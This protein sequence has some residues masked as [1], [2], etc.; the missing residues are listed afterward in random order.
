VA[1]PRFVRY[2]LTA[3]AIVAGALVTRAQIPTGDADLHLQLA[4][5]LFEETRYPEALEAYDRAITA[6][7]ADA[8]L[9]TRA[10]KGKVRTALRL[11]QFSTALEEA[12]RLRAAAAEDAEALALHG[13]ALWS[14]GLFDE[15][16]DAYDAALVRAPGA[17][18]A[19]LGRARSLATKSR[20]DEALAE[21]LAAVAAAPRGGEKHPAK[22]EK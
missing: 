19:R 10:R 8:E 11:A 22:G 21:A 17:S 4:G 2:T 1:P 5:L 18:R 15:A 6:A 20:L 13:D 7:A 3:A 9:A 16:D 12:E 14:A